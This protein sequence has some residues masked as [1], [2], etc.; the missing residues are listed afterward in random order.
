DDGIAQILPRGARDVLPLRLVRAPRL[1]TWKRT[2]DEE[3]VRLLDRKPRHHFRIRRLVGSAGGRG[4]AAVRSSA[5]NTSSTYSPSRQN[6]SVSSRSPG[7]AWRAR[8]R[9]RRAPCARPSLEGEVRLEPVP[10]A[11]AAEARLLVPAEGAR[12]VEAVVR[13]RPD[14]AC[15]Q[16]LGHP[17]DARALLRPD[18]GGQPVRRVV[19]LLDRLVGRAEREHR[20][21]GAEDLL[22]RDPV[23][24]RHVREHRR[25][26]PVA[27]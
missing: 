4:V 14:D 24:L 6:S 20:E 3:L 22:L 10:A 8:V 19:R 13:V 2:G 21:H 23:T 26:E 16:P 5:I 25:R 7:R 27:L 18:A 15:A 11:L 1:R 12:W 9:P 17:E